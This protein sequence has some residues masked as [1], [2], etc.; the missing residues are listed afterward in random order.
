MSIMIRM[1]DSTAESFIEH[2]IGQGDEKDET[3][4]NMS[5]ELDDLR[6]ELTNTEGRLREEQRK[7]VDPVAFDKL[8]DLL[9]PN[10]VNNKK[11]ECIKLLRQITREGLKET[12]TFFEEVWVPAIRAKQSAEATGREVNMDEARQK[13]KEIF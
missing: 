6:H 8:I 4:R 9:D 13:A 2:L 12:K 5:V 1:E 10:F 11:I 3:I 7:K